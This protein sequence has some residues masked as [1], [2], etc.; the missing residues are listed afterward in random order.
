MF[1]M[2]SSTPG[3]SPTNSCI[4]S[5]TCGPIGQAGV[6]SV[7]VTFTVAAVDLDAVD[8]AELDEVEPQLGVDDVGE[9]LEDVVLIDHRHRV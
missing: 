2:T 4:C 8:Q 7:N 5:E 1:G 3:S 6:V 9:R